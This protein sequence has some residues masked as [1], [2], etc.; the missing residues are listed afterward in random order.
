MGAWIRGAMEAYRQILELIDKLSVNLKSELVISFSEMYTPGRKTL[1]GFD[2][3]NSRW[4][5][6]ERKIITYDLD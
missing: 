5:F 6:T 2:M 3:D 4:Y 1:I